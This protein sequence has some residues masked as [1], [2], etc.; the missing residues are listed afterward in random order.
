MDRSKT[1]KMKGNPRT[2]F[3]YEAGNGWL[4]SWDK[5]ETWHFTQRTDDEIILWC[6]VDIAAQSDAETK[7]DLELE[8]FGD[9]LDEPLPDDL[10]E[11]LGI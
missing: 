3:R 5:G 4:S 8:L 6:D 11:M 1:Y 2:L 10:V 7:R 9:T